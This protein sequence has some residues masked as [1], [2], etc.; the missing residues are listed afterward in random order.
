MEQEFI[1][2]LILLSFFTIYDCCIDVTADTCLLLAS[3]VPK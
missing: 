1:K 3:L 2:N